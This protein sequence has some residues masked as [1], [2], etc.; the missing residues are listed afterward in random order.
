MTKRSNGRPSEAAAEAARASAEA[1]F[2][3]ANATLALDGLV[4]D[5]EQAATQRKVIAGDLT[6]EAAIAQAVAAHTGRAK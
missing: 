6:V 1:A 3:Y 4:V 2:D 5:A